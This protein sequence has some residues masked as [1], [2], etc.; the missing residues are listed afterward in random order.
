MNVHNYSITGC[1]L[2]HTYAAFSCV[3]ANVSDRLKHACNKLAF[4]FRWNNLNISTFFEN[5]ISLG[6][7][8]AQEHV[9]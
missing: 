3:N 6:K 8:S 7:Q 4:K 9:L 5:V 1:Q 2:Q